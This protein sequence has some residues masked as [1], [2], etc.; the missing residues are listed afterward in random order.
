MGTQVPFNFNSD[1]GYMVDILYSIR[2]VFSWLIYRLLDNKRD[3]L[4]LYFF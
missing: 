1:Q 3:F 4:I 2:K